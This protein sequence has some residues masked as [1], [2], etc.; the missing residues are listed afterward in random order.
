[1]KALA[2][3]SGGLDSMLAIKLLLEQGVKVEAVHGRLLFE[4]GLYERAEKFAEEE[5]IK[6]H[7]ID[8]TKGRL[9]Q[10]YINIIRKP[11]H[12]Y[13]S[14][15]NPCID[16]RI[17]MLKKAKELAK[18]IGS[19]FLVTGE[20]VGERPMTQM[21]Q[22]IKLI[23]RE[24]GVQTLKPL[25][26]RLLPPTEAEKKGW[27]DRDKLLA[28][29]GRSRKPQFELA[30][31]YGLKDF[32]TPAG[33][34]ILCEKEFAARLN[35]LFKHKKKINP[36]DVELLKL[37]RHFRLKDSKIIVGRNEKEN[38]KLKELKN[39]SDYVL[40]VPGC[41]SPITILQ[42]R[43]IKLAA[44]LTASYSD[45]EEDKVLVKYGKEKLAKEIIVKQIS[46]KEAKRIMI[47]SPA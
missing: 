20:V 6:L 38:N 8:A 31:K 44:Q 34:C 36:Q 27:V 28:I 22:A 39:K 40:E 12:G 47:K 1:M 19:G 37:G 2:L 13:G 15:I 23:E 21:P 7:V 33:G 45:A 30:K 41:G 4:A 10:E 11:K 14:A 24:A 42:G 5:G 46:K 17:F 43:N 26:A 29:S 35:D 25:S 3:L 18:K 9:F 16:C 32:P